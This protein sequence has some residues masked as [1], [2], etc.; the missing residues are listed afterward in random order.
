MGPASKRLGD[1]S[2]AT[3]RKEE[4]REL[5]ISGSPVRPKDEM[6]FRTPPSQRLV[7]LAPH[8]LG[9]KASTMGLR[10]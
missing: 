1:C 4:A 8:N 3:R 5:S 7:T 6:P 2:A 9:M 10:P